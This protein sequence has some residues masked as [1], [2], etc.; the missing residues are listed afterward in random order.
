MTQTSLTDEI[1]MLRVQLETTLPMPILLVVSS[2]RDD[3][4]KGLVASELARSMDSAGYSTLLVLA[5]EQTRNIEGALEP[6][7]LKDVADFGIAP[8]LV[9]HLDAG[10]RVMVVP[11]AKIRHTVSREAV[12]RFVET[13]R[14]T[15]AVTI[16][17]AA[18]LLTNSFAMLAAAAANGVLLTFQEGRRVCTE[19]RRL[20][21]VLEREGVPFLGVVS[22]A[23]KVISN[24]STSPSPRGVAWTKATTVTGDI[25]PSRKEQRV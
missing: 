5:D 8:Y 19:D 20:A 14:T 21:K 15:Y 11:S 2:A 7:S 22:V 4:G 10:M 16:V 23:E 9:R 6:K 17:E 18:A 3:D 13:C 1:E 25:K 12:A 24:A